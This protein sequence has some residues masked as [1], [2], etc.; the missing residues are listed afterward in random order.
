MA[1]LFPSPGPLPRSRQTIQTRLNRPKQLFWYS[2]TSSL[3]LSRPLRSYSYPCCLFW[4]RSRRCGS[5]A[6]NYATLRST[7]THYGPIPQKVYTPTGP[8][9]AIR[10]TR[11][12]AC[13]PC[14]STPSPS[15]VAAL[16]RSLATPLPGLVM[17]LRLFLAWRRAPLTTIRLCRPL[18]RT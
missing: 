11:L 3:P 17:C 4:P 13:L 9:C 6:S 8:Y 16:R 14:L 5:A 12:Q 10:K 18:T 2:F 7:T 15:P 1:I